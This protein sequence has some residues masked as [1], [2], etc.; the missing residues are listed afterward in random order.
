LSAG[1][2]KKL[3]DAAAVGLTLGLFAGGLWM[4]CLASRTFGGALD[5]GALSVSECA[6]EQELRT[7]LGRRQALVGL[8]LSVAALASVFAL[9]LQK[10]QAAREG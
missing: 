2:S 3:G 7:A 6:L 1:L 5:C 10:R 9:W 8:V 4:L